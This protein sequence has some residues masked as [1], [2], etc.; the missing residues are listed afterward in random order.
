MSARVSIAHT[1]SKAQ[2]G[3]RQTT[4]PPQPQ[5]YEAAWHPSRCDEQGSRK[6]GGED[7]GPPSRKQAL[8]ELGE[9]K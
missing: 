1:R 7:H 2:V 9:H 3:M 8:A 4:L 5:T 6:G